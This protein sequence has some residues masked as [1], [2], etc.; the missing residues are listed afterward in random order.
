M[1]FF[2]FVLAF[3]NC[4]LTFLHSW[5][6]AD[7]IA[8]FPSIFLLKQTRV[9]GRQFLETSDEINW[10][11]LKGRLKT[12]YKKE[13]KSDKRN[14]NINTFKRFILLLS[15]GTSEPAQHPPGSSFLRNRWL[16]PEAN[17]NKSSQWAMHPLTGNKHIYCFPKRQIKS[18]N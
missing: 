10:V 13:I 3:F 14:K 8:G 12:H 2:P 18:Q 17:K 1:P 4:S 7:L 15:R 5:S 16:F 11:R 6:Q 9:V